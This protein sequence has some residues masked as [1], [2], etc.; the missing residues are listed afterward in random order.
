MGGR[1][2]RRTGRLDVRFL[3]G[4]VLVLGSVVG[5]WAVV[6]G[7][8]RTEQVYAAA[9]PLAAGD[10]ITADSLVVAAVRLG[11]AT[12]HYLTPD[13]VPAEGLV[14]TRA[15]DAGELVPASAVGSDTSLRLSSVVVPLAGEPPH[16]VEPGALVDVW[17]AQET[18]DGFGPPAV[19]VPGAQVV[20]SVDGGSFLSAS[21]SRA[22]ELLVAKDR[23]ARLLQ[24]LANEDAV[25]L[26]P[27]AT[28]AGDR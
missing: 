6:A 26:V 20:R 5:V 1:G 11:G 16:G 8:E 15:V 18:E 9:S 17:A 25:S 2:R 10:R 19:L 3:L 12:S 14:V 23:V 4:I 27:V 13:D 22:V 24:A 28:P 21:G 7:A